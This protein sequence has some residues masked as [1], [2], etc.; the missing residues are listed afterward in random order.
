MAFMF[1]RGNELELHFPGVGEAC[2]FLASLQCQAIDLS[3]QYDTP[4]FRE[5]TRLMF[6]AIM[7]NFML[8]FS[9]RYP[10]SV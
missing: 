10:N 8:C 7:M 1:T 3:R 9:N 2:S 6:V 5:V 4:L